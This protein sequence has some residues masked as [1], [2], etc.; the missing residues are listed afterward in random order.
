MSCV[1]ALEVQRGAFLKTGSL[2]LASVAEPTASAVSKSVDREVARKILQIERLNVDS[3]GNGD[4]AKHLPQLKIGKDVEVFV[5]HI[6]D[7]EKP[8]YIQFIWLK[9]EGSDAIVAAKKFEPTDPSPPTLVAKD[10]KP[11]T[12]LVPYAYC[13]LHGLWIGNS[14][15]VA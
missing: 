1:G 12:M 2:A 7:P 14:D 5:P 9:D 11:G 4:K 13:N 3:N 15:V 10:I 6:M 8:H